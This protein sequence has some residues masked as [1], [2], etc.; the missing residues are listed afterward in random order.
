MVAAAGN[1]GTAGMRF[2]GGYAPVISA[3]A[4]GAVGEFPPDDPTHIQWLLNDV[5]EGDSSQHGAVHGRLGN[6]PDKTLMFSHLALQFP[7]R[8]Q[9][10]AAASDRWTTASKPEPA[11]HLRT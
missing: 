11:L 7:L 4:S 6:F 5:P 9:L 3:G 1:E 8:G 2:P 10:A